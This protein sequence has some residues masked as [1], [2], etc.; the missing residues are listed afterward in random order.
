MKGEIGARNGVLSHQQ[1]GKNLSDF[2]AL[3][4]AFQLVRKLQ[5]SRKI[6]QDKKTTSIIERNSML[7]IRYNDGQQ[8]CLRSMRDRPPER[9]KNVILQEQMTTQKLGEDAQP[10]RYYQDE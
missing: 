3:S 2:Q 9:L 10:E 5:D 7:K 6:M 1:I 4:V 8:S